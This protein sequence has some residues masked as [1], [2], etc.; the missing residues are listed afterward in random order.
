MNKV[1][2]LSIVGSLMYVMM[3]TRPDIFHD[4]GMASIYQSNS[5]KEHWKSVKRILRYLKDIVEYS[6]CYQGKKLR[7]KGYTDAD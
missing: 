6:L 2:Y 1:P 7:L 5:G 3:C 4:V